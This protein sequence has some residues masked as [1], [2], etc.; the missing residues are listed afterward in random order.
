M[1]YFG[2]NFAYL[3][4][5]TLSRHQMVTELLRQF[6]TKKKII[7]RM[8][9]RWGAIANPNVKVFDPPARQIPIPGA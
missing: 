8:R 1:V 4:I 7:T 9:S 2:S 5:L 3:F 6:K